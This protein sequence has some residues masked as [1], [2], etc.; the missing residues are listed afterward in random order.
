MMGGILSGL[1]GLF[2]CGKQPVKENKVADVY[3]G[4]RQQVFKLDPRK[5]GLEPSAENRVWAVLM[6]TGYPQAVVTLVMIADGTVSIYFSHGGGIIGLGPHEGPRKA[7][8]DLLSIA[9]QFQHYATPTSDFPLPQP[10]HTRFYFLTY[11]GIGTVD[12]IEDDLGNNRSPL[13]PLFF[14]AQD[15]ITQIRLTDEKRKAEQGGK[16]T[17]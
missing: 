2:G 11:D 8:F 12:G 10:G 15:V 6:E 5:I 1:L 4:L 16:P 7:S 13:S 9:P 14:K 3:Q 17:R